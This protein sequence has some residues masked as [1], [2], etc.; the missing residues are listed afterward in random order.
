MG[1][2]GGRI[3]GSR[4][5]GLWFHHYTQTFAA[6]HLDYQRLFKVDNTQILAL[7][8]GRLGGQEGFV[9]PSLAF[10]RVDGEVAYTKGGHVLEEVSTLTRF[11]AVALESAF[12]DDA[13][14]TDL[15]PFYRDAQVGV[16][17]SPASGTNEDV[18]AT[19]V[20]VF[21]VDLLN[22]VS[23]QLIVHLAELV[24][25]YINHVVNVVD[26]AVAQAA[27]GVEQGI[28][29]RNNGE[30]VVHDFLAVDNGTDLQEVERGLTIIVVEVDG[31]FNLDRASHFLLSDFEQVVDGFGNGEYVVLEHVDERDNLAST[32]IIAIADDL[33]VRIEGGSNE[34]QCAVFVG[35]LQV[36]SEQVET[37]VDREL[38]VL[39][40]EV[41]AVELCLGL[42][43][44]QVERAHLENTV[45][46]AR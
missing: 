5:T 20:T 29:L 34:F 11:D 27:V 33:V 30:V 7:P 31:K 16:A 6:V 13:G 22:I 21:A 17:A 3:V 43:Q 15:R 37:V 1:I 18:V 25:L 28:L 40:A 12:R 46:M 10:K 14:L 2:V 24:A 23:N 45:R 4:N 26:N 39:C 19:L 41:K 8:Y 42:S 44:G 35:I 36:K 32:R 38:A 9:E